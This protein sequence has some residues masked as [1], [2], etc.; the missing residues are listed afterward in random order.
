MDG[1]LKPDRTTEYRTR[2][3]ECRSDPIVILSRLWGDSIFEILCFGAITRTCPNTPYIKSV[4][5][6]AFKK[7]EGR[8]IFISCFPAFVF[9][10]LFFIFWRKMHRNFCWPIKSVKKGYLDCCLKNILCIIKKSSGR[11]ETAPVFAFG[12]AVARKACY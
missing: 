3:I 1:L 4:L 5:K 9:S 8:G 10:W 7:G 11:K 12:Y 6:S 2:N